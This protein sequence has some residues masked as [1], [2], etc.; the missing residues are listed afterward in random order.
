[1]T[2]PLATQSFKT[3]EVAVVEQANDLS[4]T[5]GQA[6]DQL[7]AALTKRIGILR[8][9][10]LVIDRRSRRDVD[11]LDVHTEFADFV[12][13]QPGKNASSAH[14]AMHTVGVPGSHGMRR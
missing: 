4:V 1:M 10:A 3:Q 11:I 2:M 7:D 8:R 12:P 5:I 6:L 13:A 9:V 14:E